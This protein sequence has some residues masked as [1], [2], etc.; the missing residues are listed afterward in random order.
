[1]EN[2]KYKLISEKDDY[3]K[4]ENNFDDK[5][6]YVE[7]YKSIDN[8]DWDSSREIEDNLRELQ[9]D[10]KIVEFFEES[11]FI[12]SKKIFFKVYSEDSFIHKDLFEDIDIAK[13]EVYKADLISSSSNTKDE[14]EKEVLLDKEIYKTDLVNSSNIQDEVYKA[15]LISSSNFNTVNENLKKDLPEKEVYRATLI[16]SKQSLIKSK[17]SLIKSKQSLIKKTFKEKEELKIVKNKKYDIKDKQTIYKNKI[18]GENSLSLKTTIPEKERRSFSK[19]NNVTY[20]FSNIDT[21]LNIELIQNGEKLKIVKKPNPLSVNMFYI[22]TLVNTIF[23]FIIFDQL[24]D[25]LFVLMIP[26]MIVSMIFYFML[27]SLLNFNGE[28]I[29]LTKKDLLY[30]TQLIK[31]KNIKKLVILK[32]RNRFNLYILE[33]LNNKTMVLSSEDKEDV[34]FVKDIIEKWFKI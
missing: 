15:D 21:P 10:N 29:V 24:V 2:Y 27:S 31:T 1:M 28:T 6:Y 17:Q 25:Y 14:R 30:N 26:I 7:K 32:E 34:T 16:K 5:I 9:R 11:D 4:V 20:N 23:F 33:K 19:N 3:Y 22:I 8:S 13:D 12:S 18:Y